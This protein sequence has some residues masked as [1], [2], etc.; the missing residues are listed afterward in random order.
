MKLTH[1]ITVAAGLFAAA[2]QGAEPPAAGTEVFAR[3]GGEVILVRDYEATLATAL[4]QKYYHGRP[5]EGAAARDRR[6][7]GEA[8]VIQVLLAQEAERRGIEPDRAAVQARLAEYEKRY[9]GSEAWGRARE[10]LLPRLTAELE[11]RSRVERLEAGLRAVPE[12]DE[13]EARAYY[14]ANPA[15]FTEPERLRL[16]LIL[17]RVDPGARGA[18]VEAVEAEAARL[19]AQ[20]RAGEDFAALA[21]AH[22]ADASAP[23]G[24]DLGYLHRGMLP[25]AIEKQFA[26]GLRPGEI[27]A[28]TR[29][30]EGVAIVRLDD[31][32]AAG[33]RGYDEVAATARELARRERGERAWEE[34][35]ARLRAAPSVWIDESRF[36]A[37][38]P[39]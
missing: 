36:A 17:L 14:E 1:A 12:P 34:L 32:R 31:R 23:N 4:R 2:A 21:R 19:H 28:P 5:P 8:M 3:A 29:V 10:S 22:S 39:H 30:L 25:E 18:Q 37:A 33:L 26:D 9:G 6:E 35:K 27:G 24:G 16:S 15:R 7:V 38:G 20:L 11:R 13:R